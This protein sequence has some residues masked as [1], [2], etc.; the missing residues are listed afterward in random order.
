MSSPTQIQLMGYGF[1]DRT[2]M[3]I[4][5]LA[6]NELAEELSAPIE[7]INRLIV[8]Q[9]FVQIDDSINREWHVVAILVE[10]SEIFDPKINWENKSAQWYTIREAAK[11]TLMPGF[12][13]T[14]ETALK[15]R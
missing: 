5:D 13:E 7:T 8:S 12:S 10:F 14:L 9:P 4:E 6:R 1:I 11:M 3:S 15:L 2:D